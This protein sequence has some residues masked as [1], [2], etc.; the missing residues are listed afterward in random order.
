VIV[1]SAI[2]NKIKSSNNRN[3]KREMLNRLGSYITQMKR[4]CK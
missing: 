2:I 1:G 4:A 3:G